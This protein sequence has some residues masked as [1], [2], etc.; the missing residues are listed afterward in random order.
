MSAEGIEQR[1]EEVA[2]LARRCV[3]I[4]E[5]GLDD[6]NQT[7]SSPDWELQV[8]ALRKQARMA[9]ERGLPVVLHLRGIITGRTARTCLGAILGSSHKI[10]IHSFLEGEAELGD[11]VSVF[12]NLR[13]GASPALLR[14]ENSAARDA[15]RN[16]SLRRILLETDTPYMKVPGEPRPPQGP[17]QRG[18]ADICAVAEGLAAIRQIPRDYLLD[19]CGVNARLFFSLA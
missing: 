8:F 10:Y 3:G 13:I 15:F 12:P 6:F 17:L 4:G 1:L 14:P 16:T 7:I 18:P 19:H 11:W 2:Q 5:I 9:K